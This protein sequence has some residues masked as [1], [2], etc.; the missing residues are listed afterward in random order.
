MNRKPGDDSILTDGAG[1]IV[2][3]RRFD[4]I[5]DHLA[6]DLRQYL[7]NYWVIDAQYRSA[8]EGKMMQELDKGLF[9]LFKIPTIGLHMVGV[10]IGHHSRHRL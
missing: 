1:P 8:V 5:G 7:S 9:Q 6:G 10:D 2:G 4:T 3:I